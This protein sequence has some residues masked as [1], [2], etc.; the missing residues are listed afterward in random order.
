MPYRATVFNVM[1]AAPSD[2]ADEIDIVRRVVHE[3][4][5]VHSEEQEVVLIPT[6]W[7]TH[8]APA[9]GDRPQGV[10]ND[11]VLRSADLLVAIFWARLGTAT[12]EHPSG[13]AE[14]IFEHDAV[15]KPVM[16]Y[17]SNAPIP[18]ANLDSQE[19]D[20]LR[21]FKAKWQRTALTWDYE[22]PAAFEKTFRL[23]LAMK[24][25]GDSYFRTR[26]VSRGHEPSEL[27]AAAKEMLSKG[28]TDPQGM[29]HRIPHAA[30]VMH[31][32]AGELLHNGLEARTAAKWDAALES[33]VA[34]G[35]LEQPM[36]GKT[37]Y[38]LTDAGFEAADRLHAE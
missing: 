31:Q 15:G 19:Y 32:S 25:G 20:R 2:V 5:V 11:Q 4:N 9:T 6:H 18:P 14:E 8:S 1:I 12:G 35:Y 7:G 36:P 24:V 37:G 13:T 38:R 26:M 10:I 33:L 16:L 30:G 22:S 29:I 27:S 28:A 3:W 17:F 21:Q 23:Q 34:R